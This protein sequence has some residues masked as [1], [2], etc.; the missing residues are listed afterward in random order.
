AGVLSAPLREIAIERAWALPDSPVTIDKLKIIVLMVLWSQET[1]IDNLILGEL[2]ADGSARQLHQPYCLYTLS[3]SPLPTG[4]GGSIYISF[5]NPPRSLA[6]QAFEI[7]RI[8][9]ST[10]LF[11]GT[12]AD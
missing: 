5:A 9:L 11:S 12:G 4:R 3:R 8:V 1:Q 10:I 6:L 2:L 7:R